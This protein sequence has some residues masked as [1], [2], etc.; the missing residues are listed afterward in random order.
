[1]QCLQAHLLFLTSLKRGRGILL[2]S[3]GLLSAMLTNL[4]SKIATAHETWTHLPKGKVY[5]SHLWLQSPVA[6]SPNV[7]IQE[8]VGLLIVLPPSSP[9]QHGH[10]LP[11]TCKVPGPSKEGNRGVS[12]PSMKMGPHHTALG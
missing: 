1:M 11:P 4:A 12:T 3:T 5:L 2:T 9:V 7:T 6:S 8:W 10:L